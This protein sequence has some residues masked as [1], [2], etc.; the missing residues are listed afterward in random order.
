MLSFNAKAFKK[1]PFLR[2]LIVLIAGIITQQYCQFEKIFIMTA[3]AGFVVIYI[4]YTV[5]IKNKEYGLRWVNGA[6]LSTI[7]FCLGMC[8]VYIKTMQH[9]PT[10][11]GS[12]KDISCVLVTIDEPLVEKTKT[13]KAIASIKKVKTNN[14]VWKDVSGKILIY[15]KKDTL[16]VSV[17][18]GSEIIFQKPL[19]PIQNAG[20]PGG[21]D[22]K[23]YCAFQGISH[24]VFIAPDDYIVLPQKNE[25]AFYSW[26]FTLHNGVI[27]CVQN[28]VNGKKEQGVVEALLIGY[29]DD[30]DRELNQSYSNTGVVHI[31]AISGLHLGMIY[32]GLL[33][34]LQPLSKRG[35]AGKFCSAIIILTVLWLFTFLAGAVASILRAA[36]MFSGIVLAQLLSR[37]SNIYNMLSA[38][39]FC[40]LITDPF[41]LWD[42][43]FLLSYTAILGILLLSKPIAHW[44]YFDNKILQKIWQLSAVTL[45]AQVFTLPLILY[46]FH[47]FPVYFLVANLIAVPLSELILYAGLVLLLVGKIN[48]L[49]TIM[50]MITEKLTTW[51]NNF[52]EFINSLPFVT[53]DNIS[54]NTLQSI[55]LYLLSIALVIWLVNKRSKIFILTLSIFAV[56]LG[57]SVYPGIQTRNQHKLV[58]Y[59]IPKTTAI[60]IVEG[61]SY[62]FITDL[63]AL[64]NPSNYQYV[65]KPAHVFLNVEEKDSLQYTRIN[66]PLIKTDKCTVILLNHLQKTAFIEE[67]IKADILVLSKDLQ[68][69]I[70]SLLQVIDCS[71]IVFDS[72]N[73]QWKINQWKKQCDSL[74]LPYH[75]VPETGAF[76]AEL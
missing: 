68:T 15:L 31:V 37:K 11:V 46:Y 51:L 20:N 62:K 32:G 54:I 28:F 16:P 49:A 52:I 39:A 44:F 41:L 43:G 48:V 38:S 10:W 59:N 65:F 53:I 66:L 35:R 24:Q 7:I 40:L 27:N 26:L 76:I 29:R 8:T 47:Q 12:E 34:L 36:V 1:I 30:M 17:G 73:P 13:Y 67:R 75:S 42:V 25:N 3:L 64:D 19:Q 6:L 45:S 9:Q 70:R 56:F 74:H 4:G 2:L 22:Y 5:L 14:N 55:L 23:R 50:G 18:Y 63:K 21:F 71:K 72:S 61:E 60:D 33:W 58:I 69:D 57:I